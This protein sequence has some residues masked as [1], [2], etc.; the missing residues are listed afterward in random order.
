MLSLRRLARC[1]PVR[2]KRLW[3]YSLG[4]VALAVLVLGLTAGYLYWSSRQPVLNGSD[5]FTIS[6]GTGVK[7]VAA[8]LVKAK[9]LEEPYTFTLW[10]YVEDYTTRVHAGEYA[11]PKGISVAGLLELFVSGRVIERPLTLIEGWTFKE[12][13]QALQS[14]PKLGVETKGLTGAQIMARL[15]VPDQAPEGRFFPD[16]YLYTAD[17]SD[18][19]VLKRAHAEMQKVLDEEW[20]NRDES[21]VLESKEQALILASII[22]KET[23]LPKERP[24]ISAVFQNR[25]EKGMRLQT[26]P[27]VI[28]GLGDRFNGNLTKVHLQ[29]DTPY[30]TYT[31]AGLP[32]TPIA[33]PGRASIH[34]ALHPADS[35]ALYFVAKGD[36]SHEFSDTLAEHNR[37]VARYQ[38]NGVGHSQSGQQVKGGETN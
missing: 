29:T 28:Y 2:M 5:S 38:L 30:N 8:S 35:K 21:T 3:L 36:G 18:L 33:M 9:I 27:T 32:P 14:A 11:I 31:R 17:T 23:G 13:L 34:A 25:L 7:E 37:A 4:S 24:L 15:G 20:E 19:D 6:P 26:D 16:T 10:A 12:C 1:K 22:E